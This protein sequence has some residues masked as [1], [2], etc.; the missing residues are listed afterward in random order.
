MGFQQRRERGGWW[1]E[2]KGYQQDVEIEGYT[3]LLAW[4]FRYI[5]YKRCEMLYDSVQGLK[6]MFMVCGQIAVR[7]QKL[8]NVLECE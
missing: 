5:Q 7:L 2:C 6:R 1:L 4:S 8:Q 3:K